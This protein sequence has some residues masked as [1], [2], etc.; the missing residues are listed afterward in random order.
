MAHVVQ[1]PPASTAAHLPEVECIQEGAVTSHDNSTAGHV[2]P[3]CQSPGGNNHLQV[4][5]PYYYCYTS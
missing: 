5:T 2:D 4:T 3:I 1:A